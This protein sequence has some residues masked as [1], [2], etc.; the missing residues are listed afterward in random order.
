MEPAPFRADLADAP[1]N[2]QV[3]FRET[4][5][6][7]RLRLGWWAPENPKGT[8][9]LFHGRTEYIEKYGK[10][11]RDVTNAG[12]AVITLDWRG[13]GLSDRLE[14][15]ERL[16]HVTKFSEYQH[17]VHAVQSLA[18]EVGLPS[19]RVLVAHSMGGCIGLGALCARLD[20]ERAVFSAPMWG[21]EMPTYARPLTYILP[22]VARILKTEKAYAPGT[23]P[24]N[25][26]SDTGFDENMLTTDPDTYAWLG[27][28]AASAPEF[29]LGGPSVQWVGEATL[30]NDRLYRL[31]RPPIPVLT[32]VGTQEM[33]VSVSAIE[34]MHADWESGELR[35]IQGAKHE[36]MMEAPAMR[37]RFL[38]ETLEFFSATV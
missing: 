11:V 14:E 31:P 22:P 33:I 24:T 17:D 16:G 34:R 5:D 9:Y 7:V 4:E 27:S 3:V 13:Q 37:N 23:R 28:H 32:F 38:S 12:W 6:G 15:D 35:V 25:Y 2:A 26:V 21:I 36:V 10:V 1:C 8:V 19:P 29:A 18:N 30:E 20:V